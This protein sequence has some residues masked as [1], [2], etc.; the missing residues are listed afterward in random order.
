[1]LAVFF[2]V[3]SLL[4]ADPEW[5]YVYEGDILP[6]DASLADKAWQLMGDNQFAEVTSRG[7][8]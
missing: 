3:P 4:S 2:C 5:E 7:G 6:D 1:M 8:A